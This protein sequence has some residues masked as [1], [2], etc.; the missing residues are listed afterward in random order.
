M[1]K[2]LV[3]D[4][5]GSNR[6]IGGLYYKKN[7]LFSLTQNS[8]IMNK[9][10]IVVVTEK[11]NKILFSQFEEMVN[12]HYISYRFQKEKSIKRKLL[13]YFLSF[14]SYLFPCPCRIEM[15]YKPINAIGG[16]YW[17][18]DFQHYHL[19][20]FFSE[21]E[22]EDR[23]KMNV[24]IAKSS[25]PLVLSST[26]CKR[27][28]A[29]FCSSEK[30]NVYVVP[31]VSY[32]ESEIRG[33]SQE[34]EVEILRK[35]NLEG[36]TYILVCNQFWRHKNHEMVLY[37]LNALTNLNI[38]NLTFVF[39][40]R[41]QDN[42]DPEYTEII[43]KKFDATISTSSQNIKLL[44]FID[45]TEQLTIMKNAE[46]IIQPSLFEGWGT[47]VEDAKVLDKTILLSD[48]PVHREQMNEKCILFD[49]H[50]PVALAHLIEDEIQKEHHDDIEKGIADMYKRAKEY[51]KGFEQLLKDLERK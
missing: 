50:D 48:I 36:I 10:R 24:Q 44:G 17:I 25:F 30:E 40:G 32:I 12:V 47:V 38:S 45:R 14:C 39:T 43:K 23:E 46:F 16:I 49:P 5:I 33:I 7:I 31:F 8:E 28:F 20:Q 29:N 22:R 3:I 13:L 9:Y 21:E 37:A 27:D 2:R 11:E 42:K 41:L 18:P 1:K 6:W 15:N 34:R 26:D 4:A 35:H 19:P 51:S